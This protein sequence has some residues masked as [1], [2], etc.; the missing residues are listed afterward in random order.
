MKKKIER[1]RRALIRWLGGV[2]AER[3]GNLISH[4]VSE[5]RIAWPESEEMQDAIRRCVLDIVGVFSDQGHSGTSA[6]YTVEVLGKLLRFQA[7]TPLQGTDDEWT[8]LDYNDDM[9]FQNKRCSRVFKRADGTAYDCEAVI[10]EDQNGACYTSRES[11]RDITF[12]Y[13]PTH[14]YERRDS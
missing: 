13:T 1:L 11:R 5:M 7:L 9:A 8:Q 3:D 2:P 12:P 6:P 4:A 10:F 14:R